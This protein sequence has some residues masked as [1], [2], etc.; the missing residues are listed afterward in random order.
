VPVDLDL[1]TVEL[2]VPVSAGPLSTENTAGGTD[3][4]GR[5]DVPFGQS[6]WT[7]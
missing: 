5:P 6:W 3:G 1:P 4:D 7:P 2:V